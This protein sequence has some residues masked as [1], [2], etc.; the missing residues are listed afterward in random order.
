MIYHSCM[1]AQVAPSTVEK[2]SGNFQLYVVAADFKKMLAQMNHPVSMLYLTCFQQINSGTFKHI[3]VVLTKHNE[4]DQSFLNDIPI[5]VKF[6]NT[7]IP[8][9]ERMA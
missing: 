8:N 1:D 6:A 7:K 2:L 4:N 3:N 9:L 5:L